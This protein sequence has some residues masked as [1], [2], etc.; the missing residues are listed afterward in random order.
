MAD[1]ESLTCSVRVL[2]ARGVKVCDITSSDPYV[3]L[4]VGKIS[5]K[6]KTKKK[7]LDPI[8][9]EIHSLP[10]VSFY[11]FIFLVSL[12]SF[13]RWPEGEDLSVDVYDQDRLSRDDFLGQVLIRFP[14]ARMSS[15]RTRFFFPN[16]SPSSSFHH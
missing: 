12:I 10:Y 6:T 5:K 3:V 8:W 1:K 14:E 11:S 16:L 7:T 4:S 15:G 9:D 2:H 13:N